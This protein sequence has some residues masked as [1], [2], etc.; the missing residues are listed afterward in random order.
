MATKAEIGQFM[1][2]DFSQCHSTVEE[3]GNR[4]ATVRHSIGPEE[5][6]PGGTYSVPPTR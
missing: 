5:L 4:C 6:R 3:I 2:T 1:S